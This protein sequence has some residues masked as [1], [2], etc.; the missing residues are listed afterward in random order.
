MTNAPVLAVQVPAS[1]L[2]PGD[3][4]P[5]DHDAYGLPALL[6]VDLPD[7]GPTV[8]GVVTVTSLP[9][10]FIRGSV[11]IATDHGEPIVTQHDESIAILPR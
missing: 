10:P 3:R 4:V 5:V 11:H 9:R 7:L 2:R 1:E 8:C 6:T